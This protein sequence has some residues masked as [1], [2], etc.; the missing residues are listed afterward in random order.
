MEGEKKTELQ[1]HKALADEGQRLMREFSRNTDDDTRVICLDLQ[2]T[3]PIPRISTSVAFYK[4]K[5]WMFN[6][7]VHDL[8]KKK[9]KFYVW[10]EVRA[11]RGAVEIATCIRKWL[12]EE[13]AENDFGNLIVFSD[14][15][16]GQKKIFFNAILP[17][18][19]A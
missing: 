2:Q 10:D 16:G 11:G 1:Q 14:N 18:G 12:D 8:K 19:D 4:R 9:S 3:Q 15:C 6:V 17:Q 5:L 13:Y 7:R